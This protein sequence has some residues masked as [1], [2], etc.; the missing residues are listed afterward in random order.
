MTNKE[1]LSLADKLI[2]Q[3]EH[4]LPVAFEDYHLNPELITIRD[5]SRYQVY[6]IDDNSI[7]IEY[8]IIPFESKGSMDTQGYVSVGRLNID[9]SELIFTLSHKDSEKTNKIRDIFEKALGKK[10]NIYFKPRMTIEF[11]VK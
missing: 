10:L 6:R 1:T 11:G 4:T 2:W 9:K 5:T 3:T 8:P 7:G